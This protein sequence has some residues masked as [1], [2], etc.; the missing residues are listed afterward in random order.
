LLA[1]NGCKFATVA[2]ADTNGALR[3]QMVSRRSL[4]GILA[5]R[6]GHGPASR[7]RWTRP[8]RS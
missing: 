4:P 6:H 2:M 1:E 8:T 3:G 5:S 7:W